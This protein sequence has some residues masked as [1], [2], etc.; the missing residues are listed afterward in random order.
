MV[1]REKGSAWSMSSFGVAMRVLG[2]VEKKIP[3]RLVA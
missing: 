1:E 3:T 2:K